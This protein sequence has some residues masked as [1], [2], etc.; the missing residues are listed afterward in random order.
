MKKLFT[1]CLLIL[2]F[3]TFA[4]QPKLVVGIV[5][6]Q[7]R[8]DYL[9]RFSEKYGNGGFKRLLSG[10]FECRNAQYN[11]VPTYTGP[12]HA[13]IYTGTTPAI[14][15]IAANDWYD[16]KAKKSVYCVYDKTVKSVGTA[17]EN[18]LMS[19]VNL[20]ATTIGD[21]IKVAT[22]KKAKVIGI[23]LKD[24]SS[25]LPAGHAADAAYWFDGSTGNFITSSFYRNDL[26]QWL[27]DF[28]AK[29]L[30]LDYLKKGWNTLL[31]IEKY[32]ESISDDNPYEKAPNKKDKPVFPYEFSKQLGKNNFEI[33]RATPY[34][35]TLTKD[36]ALAVIEGENLGKDSICDMLCISFSSTDYV[37]HAFGPKS[38]E[39]E[40]VYIRLDKD[41]EELF[42]YLDTKVGKG[43]Y[44]LFLTA[45]HG[46][47][48][49]PAY[50]QSL[51]INAGY[52]DDKTLEKK[53]KTELFKEYG[54]SLVMAYKNQ[55][56]YLNDSIIRIKKA[57]KFSVEKFCADF[58]LSANE[59]SDVL[60]GEQ[61]NLQSQNDILF[62]G[63]VQRGYHNKRSGDILVCYKPGYMEWEK[64][65]TTHGTAFSY[66]THVPL[67]FYGKGITTGSTLR[68]IYITDIASTISQLLNIPYT[69]GNIGNPVFEAIK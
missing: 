69:N 59:V 46:A 50:L 6:D 57:D 52:V 43:N 30:P 22:N 10:G 7:M 49:V 68:T 3:Y 24:R 38:I 18:G 44:T 12:G 21:E 63:L 34:G 65:G 55:Q 23:A 31:P 19:P 58:F 64:T 67:I 29:K 20:D 26:P 47:S 17:S 32:T 37:G 33:I 39:L 62:R 2:S 13:S 5:I 28:N 45:D 60:L 56:I 14:H 51:K 66:D 54:D 25:I 41:L 35:N 42:S 61:L 40:D 48:E 16:K 9:F 1:Y 27:I 15:G 11:Y 8:Y 36:V 53:L 4:Q